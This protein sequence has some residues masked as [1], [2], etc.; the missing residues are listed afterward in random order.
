MEN[1][2]LRT[3]PKPILGIG[4]M[5][6]NCVDTIYQYS[7]EKSKTILLIASRRQI[8]TSKLWRGYVNNWT[9][10]EFSAYL[11]ALEKIWDKSNVIVC[12]DHGGPWQ[13]G[14][15]EEKL[16]LKKAMENALIS[17]YADIDAD[18]DLLHLDPSLGG[19]EEITLETII[20]RVKELLQKCH[21]YSSKKGKKMLYEIGTE[22]ITG[23][24]TDPKNFEIFLKDILNFCNSQNV[25]KPV[26][27]VGQTQSLIREMRQIGKF[28]IPNTKK[29]L[30]ICEKHGFL[31]KEHNADYLSAY[32][33][34]LRKEIG[35][36][37]FN[38]APEFGVIESTAFID[39]CWK[40]GK[41]D[42]VKRF[43]EISLA[44][45]RWDKWILDERYISDYDK[46]LIAGHYIFSTKE[47]Q[48]LREQLDTERLDTYI[49]K[50]LY[51]RLD[52]YAS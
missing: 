43:L 36:H 47:F 51:D 52:F 10:E 38:V 40:K 25:P 26:F 50:T 41:R 2:S 18:F 30:Q 21:A 1:E 37:A 29:L 32:Q 16:D 15:W 22:E 7:Q 5:S 14:K 20:E 42:L 11:S 28:N 49:R 23:K 35:V 24:T 9:T 34:S 13:G 8:E 19:G 44:S 31:M 6:K 17:Y 46:S 4:P 3:L 39:F 48:E 27:I 12:R 33:L 45:K